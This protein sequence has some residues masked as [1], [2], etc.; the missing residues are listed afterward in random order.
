MNS[1]V[2]AAYAGM[3]AYQK[4]QQF[5]EVYRRR[6]NIGERSDSKIPIT[7]E[8]LNVRQKPVINVKL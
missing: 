7:E 3:I 6:H 8:V 5:Q 4:T 1:K 2:Y